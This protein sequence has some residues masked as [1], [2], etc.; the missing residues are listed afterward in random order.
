[1][2]LYLQTLDSFLLIAPYTMSFGVGVF[3]TMI[4]PFNKDGSID[5]TLVDGMCCHLG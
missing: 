4:T 5:Y 1:M 2:L 3:P